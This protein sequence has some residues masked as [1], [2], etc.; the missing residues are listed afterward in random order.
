V[1]SKRV[2]W[3]IIIGVAAVLIM[4]WRVT[5]FPARIVIINQ[6]GTTLAQVAVDSGANRIDLGSIGNGETRR[7]SIDPTS[8]LVL[9]FRSD[10]NHVW[11]ATEA[12]TAGQSLVLYVTPC[13]HVTPRS[14]IG[15]FVR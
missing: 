13:G 10:T 9:T 6:S 4:T 15:S 5:R 1:I 2:L 14:R 11:R 7:V 8:T 12:L 3:S